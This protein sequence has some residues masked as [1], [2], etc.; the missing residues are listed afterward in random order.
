VQRMVVSQGAKVVLVGAALGI[1]GAIASKK[2]LGS[3]LFGVGAV[4]PIVFV[5][6]PLMLLAVG[7]L[8]AWLPA[9]R[10]SSVDPMEVLRSD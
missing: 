9:R 2:A 6:M 7:M 4:D 8:A 1:A 10:A 5:S 3:L